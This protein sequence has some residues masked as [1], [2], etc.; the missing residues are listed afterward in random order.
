MKYKNEKVL[1]IFVK[2]PVRGKV[3]TRL[4]KTIGEE[5]ALA[6]Y[7]DLLRYTHNLTRNIDCYKVVFYSDFID[8]TDLWEESVFHK[9]IQSGKDLGERMKNSFR[10]MFGYG[11][12]KVVIIGSDCLE[13]SSLII[14]EAF[15]KLDDT[16]V[17][18][19]PASDGGYYL[20]GL[21]QIHDSLFD[22]K[23]WSTSS[24]LNETIEELTREGVGFS[25]LPELSDIDEEKDLN[26]KGPDRQD[27]RGI[28]SM[29]ALNNEKLHNLTTEDYDLPEDL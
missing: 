13:I 14:D 20:M 27:N 24:L 11:F 2:N 8:N 16:E 4:A 9:E 6:V 18:I 21:K 15:R 3:K 22:N 29:S 23:S 25:L 7:N 12:K 1:I 28:I 10:L 5:K 19:G 26:H 17:V